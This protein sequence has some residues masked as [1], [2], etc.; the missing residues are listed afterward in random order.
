MRMNWKHCA[1]MLV[2][3][4]CMVEG[5]ARG[6]GKEVEVEELSISLYNKPVT[7]FRLTLDRSERFVANQ[8]IAHVAEVEQTNPF[9]YERS[10]IYENIRYSPIA[11]DRDL[12]LYF[13]LKSI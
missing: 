11:E 2:V 13:L 7:G 3:M 5:Y 8:I 6:I 4:L 1:G 10:I 12:S 9:Q